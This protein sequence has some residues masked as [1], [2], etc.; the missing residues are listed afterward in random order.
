MQRERVSKRKGGHRWSPLVA[1][2]GCASARDGIA[3]SLQL[4]QDRSRERLDDGVDVTTEF[5]PRSTIH[6]RQRL[7]GFLVD[8]E[9]GIHSRH[10]LPQ[11]VHNS[12]ADSQGET[13][14][15]AVE[16]RRVVAN[17]VYM[18]SMDAADLGHGFHRFVEHD[19]ELGARREQTATGNRC[20]FANCKCGSHHLGLL[21]GWFGFPF[22]SRT[23]LATILKKI[24][25]IV[26][27]NRGQQNQWIIKVLFGNSNVC[28][29]YY[30]IY[31]KLK[32]GICSQL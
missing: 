29:T 14:D 11:S 8:V 16:V 25:N 27:K 9:L 4:L 26:L 10:S 1:R 7:A 30:I 17:G 15:R 3:L 22:R 28:I 24:A 2:T 32:W 12:T 21:G 13:K 5:L 31:V 18:N 20:R 6:R 19:G 23:L